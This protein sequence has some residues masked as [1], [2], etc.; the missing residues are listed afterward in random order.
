MN[1]KD[2]FLFYDGIEDALEKSIIASGKTKKEI[3]SVLYPDCQIET[4]KSRLSRALSPEHTDVHIS[5]GHMTAIMKEARPDDIINYLCDEFNFE[6]PNNKTAEK[7]KKNIQAEI[8]EI[9]SRLKILIRQLPA[10]EDE[11]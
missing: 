8:S 5:I 10:L 3:A 4:A 6:R 11:K 9:N 1:P 2:E 7:I